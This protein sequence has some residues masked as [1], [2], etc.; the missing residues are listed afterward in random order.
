MSQYY[1][2]IRTAHT[3]VEEENTKHSKAGEESVETHIVVVEPTSSAVEG[4]LQILHTLFSSILTVFFQY[5]HSILTVFLQYSY[6]ILTVF[7][8]SSHSTLTV[9]L[10]YSYSILTVFPQYSYSILTVFLQYS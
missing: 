7:L 1:K 5:P 10:Q 9:F 3:A 8:Q 2:H 6:S 4:T